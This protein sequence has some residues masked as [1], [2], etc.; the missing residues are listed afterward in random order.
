MNDITELL[1]FLHATGTSVIPWIFVVIVIWLII[2]L[3]PQ[4]V[5][6]I[7]SRNEAKLAYVQKEGERNEIIRNCSA[8]IEACT[9]ALEMVSHDREVLMEHI[10]EHEAMS[11][12]RMEHIQAVVDQCRDEI[13][14]ARGDI[15]SNA[16]KLDAVK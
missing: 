7:E 2:Q 9:A 12:E 13:I 16:I 4:L 8:T 3:K 15:K 10:N 11:R 14:R 1:K 5:K 6:Y